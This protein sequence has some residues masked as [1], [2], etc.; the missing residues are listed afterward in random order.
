MV[1]REFNPTKLKSYFLFGPRQTG[2]STFVKSLLTDKDLYIDLLPQRNFLNYAKNPGRVREEILAHLKRYND[3]LCVIDEIQKIPTLL[4]E[5]HELIESKRLRFI[6]TGS[7]ARK[8]RRGG[9]NLLAGRAYTYRLFPLTFSELGSRFDLERALRTG[10]LPVLWGAGTEDSFEFLKSY[11]ETYLKEEVAAEGLVRNIGPFAQFLDIAAANDGETVNYNNVARE[12]SVSVKTVQQ[13]FQILEDTFL[14][15]KI[16]AWSRSGRRRMVSHPRYYFFDTGVTNILAHTLTNQLNP[17]IF[18][19]RFEQFVI[20]QLMAFIDYKRLD[21]QLFYWRTNHG[22]EVD[23]L[24]CQGNHIVCALEIKSSKNISA[25]RLG[26]L[27]S[28]M[29]DNPGVPAYVL[30]KG[31]KKRL[32]NHDIFLMN[33]DDFILEGLDEAIS[34]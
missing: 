4:D 20:C 17:K 27:K 10:T 14:A 9:A 11:T 5:V 8:L 24:I 28:F 2:K 25:K 34:R 33:W 21:F 16:P 12:C 6:L 19:R 7:S 30:G 29:E 13:Y 32:L 23:V 1:T 31:Q 15:F 26:G 18:G 3:P 22:A